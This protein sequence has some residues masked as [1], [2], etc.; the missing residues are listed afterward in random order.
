MERG[1][2]RD[3]DERRAAAEARARARAGEPVDDEGQRMSP[4]T[5][6]A[7]DERP[8]NR[9]YGG[10]DVYG[11]RRLVAIFGGLVIVAVLFMLLGG[12]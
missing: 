11:R 5:R 3:P 1:G 4:A 8:M 9:Y 2:S 7:A 12:C 6:A 10:P